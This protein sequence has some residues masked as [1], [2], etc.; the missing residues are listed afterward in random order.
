[1][2][3]CRLLFDLLKS[4]DVHTAAA[5]QRRKVYRR[6]RIYPSKRDTHLSESGGRTANIVNRRN[7]RRLHG[8]CL[9]LLHCEAD[10]ALMR[11]YAAHNRQSWLQAGKPTGQKELHRKSRRS[12]FRGGWHI[13]YS[14][15]VP[16]PKEDGIPPKKY[17]VSNLC[18]GIYHSTGVS[19]W[20][21][22]TISRSVVNNLRY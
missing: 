17:H 7:A 19:Q 3:A 6:R 4:Y 15:H 13:P 11:L 9:F 10:L 18:L 22:R 8:S 12:E 21:I 20:R 14:L 2:K 5:P 1:M 16:V